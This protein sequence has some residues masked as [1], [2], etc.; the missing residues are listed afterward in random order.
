LSDNVAVL[1]VE[2]E[3]FTRSKSLLIKL[4]GLGA[5]AH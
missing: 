5:V 1:S 2:A 4:D 3:E